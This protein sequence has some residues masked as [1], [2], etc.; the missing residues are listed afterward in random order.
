MDSKFIYKYQKYKEKYLKLRDFLNIQQTGGFQ[1]L[2]EDQLILHNLLKSMN[3]NTYISGF[4]SVFQWYN[5]DEDPKSPK[6]ITLFGETHMNL[7]TFST[8]N[9]PNIVGGPLVQHTNIQILEVLYK[10]F[11]GTRIGIDFYL[12]DWYTDIQMTKY[13]D[14]A[15]RNW[16]INGIGI[17]GPQVFPGHGYTIPNLTA[18]TNT[19]MRVPNPQ[20]EPL[21]RHEYKKFQN[22]RMHYTEFRNYRIPH[23]VLPYS[24]LSVING[25]YN[26]WALTGAE[27]TC[28]AAR[29]AVLARLRN[30]INN[31][32]GVPSFLETMCLYKNFFYMLAGLDPNND[33]N[34]LKCYTEIE[35]KNEFNTIF[36]TVIIPQFKNYYFEILIGV[37]NLPININADFHISP[38]AGNVADRILYQNI[39]SELDNLIILMRKNMSNLRKYDDINLNKYILFFK[40]YLD[41]SSIFQRLFISYSQFR[42][43]M[44]SNINIL[45][46]L[47][48]LD[49]TII[50]IY[51]ISRSLKTF[52]LKSQDKNLSKRSLCYNEIGLSKRNILYY[53]GH[54]HTNIYYLFWKYYF[55]RDSD[56]SLK[57]TNSHSILSD[58]NYLYNYLLTETAPNVYRMFETEFN[59]NLNNYIAQKY[60]VTFVQ[61]AYDFGAMNIQV[62]MNQSYNIHKDSKTGPSSPNLLNEVLCI[63]NYNNIF[64]K[65]LINMAKPNDERIRL[66]HQIELNKFNMSDIIEKY[67]DFIQPILQRYFN[68]FDYFE[69]PLDN[70]FVLRTVQPA[71][72]ISN[73][74]QQNN[75]KY[76]VLYN[77]GIYTNTQIDNTNA[78]PPIPLQQNNQADSRFKREIES[79]LTYFITKH[80]LEGKKRVDF[81]FLVVNIYNY[82]LQL[83]HQNRRDDIIRRYRRAFCFMN[84]NPITPKMMQPYAQLI[85]FIYKG[86]MPLRYLFNEFKRQ[87]TINIEDLIERTF[88]GFFDI[89]DNDFMLI[90]NIPNM[91]DLD[92]Q[93]NQEIYDCRKEL[94]EHLY[95][96]MTSLNLIVLRYIQNILNNRINRDHYFNF[97][98]NSDFIQKE[99]LKKLLDKIQKVVI[100]TCDIERNAGHNDYPYANIEFTSVQAYE[101]ILYPSE[102][103]DLL[104]KEYCN[105]NNYLNLQNNDDNTNDNFVN[106]NIRSNQIHIYSD[107][108]IAGVQQRVK[109][110]YNADLILDKL[111][112]NLYEQGSKGPCYVSLNNDLEDVTTKFSLGRIKYN[113][114]LYGRNHDPNNLINA[115]KKIYYDISGELI[116]VS[117]PHHKNL[118]YKNQY[119]DNDYKHNNYQTY[120]A[121]TSGYNSFSLIGF[122]DDLNYV[123]FKGTG[124]PIIYTCNEYFGLPWND[125]KYFKRINR[126][127]YLGFIQ[128]FDNAISSTVY[129][130]ALHVTINILED[131]KYV[132]KD[133]PNFRYRNICRKLIHI[134]TICIQPYIALN[135][136]L[137]IIIDEFNYLRYLIGPAPPP[138]APIAPNEYKVYFILRKFSG[139]FAFI[140]YIVKMII[141]YKVVQNGTPIGVLFTDAE[142]RRFSQNISDTLL[143]IINLSK[144]IEQIPNFK[145]NNKITRISYDSIVR[146]K[147]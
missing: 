110:I 22:T 62:T 135:P 87:F 121:I 72:S 53:H 106:L 119:I 111:G 102:D 63:K 16:S 118:F 34:N 64:K 104:N 18:M 58:Y 20:T 51:T 75:V 80:F 13:L 19:D 73:Y 95:N 38:T 86:G 46:F 37:Y 107:T 125:K 7:D 109:N 12:E 33:Y 82:T 9:I 105:L 32:P 142:Y 123:L 108:L 114:R 8:C 124:D 93:Q 39:C 24:S 40:E 81:M 5:K 69:L 134:M 43:T 122:I 70:S 29:G 103:Y 117:I 131:I 144:R 23:I 120:N 60:I 88:S 49:I 44:V 139:F 98:N 67:Q 90:I 59:S 14:P 65:I 126:I 25:T 45:L 140:Y 147:V 11:K 129:N 2:N 132:F 76:M 145:I 55:K 42:A 79:E 128:L 17:L 54:W 27:A 3:E 94:Y 85:K 97:F 74:I 26:Y 71:I 56:Y 127:V 141:F 48:I 84:N 136:N 83:W 89:S 113:F 21:K 4:T 115:D 41:F 78:N 47:T 57:I 50:D 91:Y 28:N 137:Q 31:Q 66:Y 52:S 30:I 68:N 146:D 133:Y 10:L 112:N 92:A 6:I 36:N 77:D 143:K 61:K 130:F 101:D 99:Q 100:K 15:L 35:D 96:E 138:P 116:D 1:I